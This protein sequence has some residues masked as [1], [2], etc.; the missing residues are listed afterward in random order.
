MDIGRAGIGLPDGYFVELEAAFS[1]GINILT[2]GE[3]VMNRFFK[4]F[5]KK[6]DLRLK[7]P[8]KPQPFYEIVPEPKLLFEHKLEPL[9]EPQP[10]PLRLPEIQKPPI[11]ERIDAMRPENQRYPFEKSVIIAENYKSGGVAP[12]EPM[13]LNQP[14]EPIQISQPRNPNVDYRQFDALA[15]AKYKF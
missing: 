13:N 5:L 6:D 4:K 7:E 11:L 9:F 10:K 2:K 1:T 12:L 8:P 15:D 3:F 14:F